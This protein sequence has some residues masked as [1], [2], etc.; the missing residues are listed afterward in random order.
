MAKRILFL[1]FISS[2]VL[3]GLFIPA[4]HAATEK[5]RITLDEGFDGKVK[6][7][8]GFPV[9]VTIENTGADFSGDLLFQFS[10]TYN[11][12]GSQVVPVELPKDSKKT[13]S[14]TLPGSNEEFYYNGQN[15]RT[16]FLY[17]GSWKNG[18]EIDYIGPKTLKPKFIDLASTVIG[19]LSDSP[20]RLKEL[21]VL[22][23]VQNETI[24]LNET[25]LPENELGLEA[26]DLLIIDEFK[27]SKL[28]KLQREAIID[29]V[30]SGGILIAGGTP[31]ASQSYSSIY[32][33]LPM[34]MDQEDQVEAASSFTSNPNV[35]K[36]FTRLPVFIGEV[37]KES[38]TEL[39]IGDKPLVINRKLGTGEIWQTA[40][41]I[42]D[43]PLSSWKGYGEWFSTNIVQ[44]NIVQHQNAKGYQNVF[45]MLANEFADVNEYFPSS[46][47]SIGQI[48][49]ILFLYLLVVAP[50]LYF[51]LKKLDKREHA[52]WLIA[53]VSIVSSAGIF[54]VGA[55][56]RI[57]KPQLNQ[58]EAYIAGDGYLTGIKAI[59]LLSNTSGDYEID[60]GNGKFNGAPVSFSYNQN[61]NKRA[62][63]E[64][65]KQGIIFPNVEYWSTRS[66]IGSATVQEKGKF[67]LQ[68]S[69]DGKQLSGEIIN[70]FPYDF[71]DLILWSG[72]EKIDLGSLKQGGTITVKKELKQD[73]LSAPYNYGY[74]YQPPSS[75][76]QIMKMKKER[77][78]SLVIDYLYDNAQTE[79]QPILMGYTKDQILNVNLSGKQSIN[80]N[81]SLISQPANIESKLSGPFTIKNEMFNTHLN[82]V[83][84]SIIN[85]RGPSK[86]VELDDGEYDYVLELP[87]QVL[88]GKAVL[89]ELAFNAK[90]GNVSFSLLNQ[91][92][93]DFIPIDNTKVVFKENLN[94][95]ISPQ[96]TI[97]IKLLKTGQGN[98]T[99]TL[100][101]VIVKGE[102][103]P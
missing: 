39:K 18:K 5:I 83:R 45:E 58:M 35:D 74:N 10:P 23:N 37:A 75:K 38:K 29:W 72:G 55:K 76:V 36:P 78:E 91:T 60:Y 53:V 67:D 21:K 34:K 28:T 101:T 1:L 59:T 87:K 33:M 98:P 8:A 13:Y 90:S 46:Q 47:F 22:P 49:L 71:D 24:I 64:L 48:A 61:E 70:K 54:G 31:S 50:L 56:D 32:S 26:L 97:T 85:D 15:K 40:F 51:L 4:A 6:T 27:L 2:F 42:G 68:L 94:Q 103:Q 41:S 20:D 95:Y 9:Q 44:P 77:M 80:S 30:K 65:G 102:I 81:Y 16:I 14:I 88:G 92:T 17:K 84:G 52:W 69:Y 25:N 19:M 96:G 79:N 43:E 7:G 62:I 100:P 3:L 73:Y 93:G 57:S 86:Q 89:K 66:Y 82:V 63:Q 11:S 99:V 12:S